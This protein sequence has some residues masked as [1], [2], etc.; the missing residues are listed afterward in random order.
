MTNLAGLQQRFMASLMQGG[1]Q[2]A[3]ELHSEGGIATGLGLGIYQHAYSA[4]LAT[5]AA[6]WQIPTTYLRR[7]GAIGHGLE[8]G[9]MFA[10]F[11]KLL[12]WGLAC[13]CMSAM[14]SAP[15][16]SGGWLAQPTA[17]EVAA[18]YPLRAQ[19]A[20]VED[21][22][23]LRCQVADNGQLS[24]CMVV[25]EAPGG[26]GFGDAA[27]ALAP[28]FRRAGGQQGNTP[29][30]LPIVF[31]LSVD[32]DTGTPSA[33]PKGSTLCPDGHDCEVLN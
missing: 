4:R 31:R 2:A 27:L 6:F 23:L 15:R 9:P 18:A 33:A 20:D 5:C 19:R 16:V 3:G 26:F 30:D 28:K 32:S 29:L 13:L 1:D 25:E 11:A 21:R 8:T 7:S 14:A 24:K 12:C 10:R 17:S 22:A